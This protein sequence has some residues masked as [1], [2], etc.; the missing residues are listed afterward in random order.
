MDMKQH[1]LIDASL[2][3]QQ[4]SLSRVAGRAS[5]LLSSLQEIDPLLH[6]W[7]Q[8]M[9]PETRNVLNSDPRILEQA[10]YVQSC[11]NGSKE[12]RLE[13]GYCLGAS[14]QGDTSKWKPDGM[15]I[16]MNAG[17]TNSNRIWL[18]TGLGVV[19]DPRLVAYTTFKKI[20][21][22]V[23]DAFDPL[24]SSAYPAALDRDL[25]IPEGK[26]RPI[27]AGWMV[28]LPRELACHITPP[29]KAIQQTREDGSLFMAATD[30]TFDATNPNHIAASKA[31]QDAIAPMNSR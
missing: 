21:F 24:F 9:G 31:I 28:L 23:A 22:A 8:P 19:P 6:N 10:I 30:E 27:F 17:G 12:P 20:L 13:F 2:P 4:E 16:M 11:L 15:T 5:K 14:N 29:P 25:M 1:F 3:R 18:Q 7:F 26:K